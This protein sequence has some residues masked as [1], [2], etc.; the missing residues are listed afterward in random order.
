MP[1][2]YLIV[3]VGHALLVV[4]GGL[5]VGIND[6]VRGNTVGIVRLSPGVDGVNICNSR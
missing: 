4:A 2:N 5:I 3:A 1:L 6:G